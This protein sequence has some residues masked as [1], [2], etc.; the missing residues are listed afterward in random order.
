MP[1]IT[2]NDNTHTSSMQG[3]LTTAPTAKD[4]QMTTGLVHCVMKRQIPL[5]RFAPTKIHF[6]VQSTAGEETYLVAEKKSAHCYVIVSRI[7]QDKLGS[8]VRIQSSLSCIT[9]ALYNRE[10]VQIATILYKVPSVVTVL[11]DAPPRHVQIALV[12][13]HTTSD[14]M[15]MDPTWFEMACK[16]SIR[17]EGNLSAVVTAAHNNSEQQVMLFESK[18]PY[19][20][21]GGRVGLNFRGRGREASSKNTQIG[22]GAVIGGDTSVLMQM[23]KWE[24]DVYN[25][26][27]CAPFSLLHAFAFGLAQLDL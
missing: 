16:D 18:T 1:V 9:Y 2:V 26:D 4:Y 12:P 23:A 13:T 14:D 20:K 6:N 11:R 19:V 22:I 24:N 10:G 27:F 3:L 7:D 17:K 25:V 5:Q 21:V 8:L 15:K